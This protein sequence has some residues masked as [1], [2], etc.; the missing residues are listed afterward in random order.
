MWLVRRALLW[1]LLLLPLA[2]AGAGFLAGP[3]L[4][5][6]DATVRL[7]ESVRAA[8]GAGLE[9][10][11][12]EYEAFRSRDGVAADLFAEET[13][14]VRTFRRGGA[15]FGAWCGLVL[16]LRIAGV[17]RLPRQATYEID[18][19]A[20]VSCA[21]CFSSCPRELLRREGPVTGKA[22]DAC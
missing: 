7:A 2:G 6:V 3:V 11:T 8:A 22:D 20:C 14:I 4:A 10:A 9:P 1:T 16:A 21:R 15:W 13:R 19:A 12:L 5:R 18:P 17:A